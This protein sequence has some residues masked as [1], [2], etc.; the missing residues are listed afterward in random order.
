MGLGSRAVNL[1]NSLTVIRI[2][3]VPLLVVVLL[4]KFEG[5]QLFGVSKELMGAAIFGVASLTDWLDG[6]LARRRQQVTG[7]G[8]W[9]DPLADKL[10]VTAAL[11]S[12]V[13]MSLAP[14][15]MV[16]L[17]LGREFSV[18]VLRSIAHARGQTLPASP[19]GKVKMVAQVVAIMLLILGR[20]PL[21]VVG[22]IALWVA[23]IAALVSAV[24][25]YRRVISLVPVRPVPLPQAPALRPAAEAERPRDRVSA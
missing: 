2:F 1:P 21:F 19:V 14:A 18:T 9:M 20:G 13:Q 4:T 11:V 25:Y 3:L 10:L 8:Q 6:F 24:D 15:W 22:Q 5:W 12:L 23:T 7:F 17:I 16:A